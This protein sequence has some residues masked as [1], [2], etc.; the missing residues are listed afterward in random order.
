LVEVTLSATVKNQ[1]LDPTVRRLGDRVGVTGAEALI[2]SQYEHTANQTTIIQK[3]AKVILNSHSNFQITWEEFD[4][5]Q[6]CGAEAHLLDFVRSMP[7]NRELW[8]VWRIVQQCYNLGSHV[9][10]FAAAHSICRDLGFRPNAKSSHN[11]TNP[12]KYD[13]LFS[14]RSLSERDRHVRQYNGVR[15][16]N[17]AQDLLDVVIVDQFSYQ[18]KQY[19]STNVG[20]KSNGFISFWITD[21]GYHSLQS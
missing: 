4:K 21:N 17:T 5:A 10:D 16:A 8:T 7:I 1:T 12:T 2:D 3:T 9:Y 6:R 15:Q 19:A 14:S 18:I 13:A 20:T 11:S